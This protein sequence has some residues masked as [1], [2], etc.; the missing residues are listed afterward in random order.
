MAVR[1]SLSST[2]DGGGEPYYGPPS[3]AVDQRG[4]LLTTGRAAPAGG[5][6]AQA[7]IKDITTL[8]MCYLKCTLLAF[9]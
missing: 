5:V 4:T 7:D 2:H 3:H 9:C 6:E 1:Q 8:G